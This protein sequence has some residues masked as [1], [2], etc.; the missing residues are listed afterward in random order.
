MKRAFFLILLVL[1]SIILA[2][3]IPTS[4]YNNANNL[5]GTALRQALHDIIDN[6]SVKSYS[7]LY[8]HFA[9]TD[10][11]SNGLIWDIYSDN[12]GGTPPYT[13]TT[14]QTCSN[15]PGYENGCFNREHSWPQSWFGGNQSSP[16]YS[17]LFHVY[18]SI[19]E[20]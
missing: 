11:K 19:I 13:Y 8:T 18:P 7:S 5:T 14:A 17:D 1:Q 6:H 3:Q 15:T 20:A 4:Y 10:I 16:M 2:A 9:T 12:P